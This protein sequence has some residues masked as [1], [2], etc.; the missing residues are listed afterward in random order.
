[1]GRR[2][3]RDPGCGGDQLHQLAPRD[4]PAVVVGEQLRQRIHRSVSLES[5]EVVLRTR[6]GPEALSRWDGFS[7]RIAP[8]G[9]TTIGRSM[10]DRQEDFFVE[11]PQDAT[12][13]L[14]EAVP[15]NTSL[16]SSDNPSIAVPPAG[17]RASY[18][19]SPGEQILLRM[20]V[21]TLGMTGAY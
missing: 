2:E 11:P 18:A 14:S 7:T 20:T 4:F 6:R 19:A 3:E 17:S 9:G 1:A 16:R 8:Q 15:K 10:E 5:P 21:A 12:R 13:G